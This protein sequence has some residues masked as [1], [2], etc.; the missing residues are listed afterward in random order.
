MK[1]KFD[2]RSHIGETHGIYTI[3]DVMDQKDKHGR[4]IYKCVCSQ[5]GYVRMERYNIISCQSRIVTTCTHVRVNGDYK[6]YGHTWTNKR[7]ARI[8]RGMI[9]RCYNT[10]DKDYRWYGAKGVIIDPEW[11]HNPSSF[12]KWALANGYQDNLT[13]DRIDSNKG[14]CP[15]NCRWMSLEEN[16]RRAGNV[17]WLTVNGITLTGRQWAEKLG[18]GALAI[19]KYIKAHGVSKTKELIV[20]MLNDPIVSK[21]RQPR[22]TWFSVYGIQI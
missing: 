22:Q 14:Y 5:C 16:S 20:A 21:H 10:N 17:N 15:D 2:P 19:D 3:V 1:S 12:E 8:F 13:I 18:L 7:I 11:L 6:P 9:A 4:W